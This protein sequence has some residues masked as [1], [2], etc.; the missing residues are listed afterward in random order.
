MPESVCSALA[1]AVTAACANV[2]VHAYVD[3]ESPGEIEVRASTVDASL[4]VE[5]RDDG[6]GMIARLDS[7]GLG[8]G[9][10]LIAQLSDA[11]EILDRGER[12]GVTLRMHFKLAD[13]PESDR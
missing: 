12:P 8:L 13:R 11:V 3:A 6:R 7:A 4:V 1:L 5:V 9:L 2:V 10:R